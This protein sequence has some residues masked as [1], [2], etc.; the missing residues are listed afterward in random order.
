MYVC[1]YHNCVWGLSR[2]GQGLPHAESVPCHRAIPSTHTL[3]CTCLNIQ[4]QVTTAITSQPTLHGKRKHFPFPKKRAA[5]RE[6]LR[7][8]QTLKSPE[9]VLNSKA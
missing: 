5:L 9:K 3:M 7:D 4:T 8:S 1:V 2:S 6:F